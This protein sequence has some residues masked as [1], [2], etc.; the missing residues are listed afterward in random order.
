MP[1]SLD[2]ISP[3]TPMG[4]NLIADG[5]TFRVWAPNAQCRARPRRFQRPGEGRRQPAHART[6]TATGAASSRGR[7]TGTA[8]CSTSIGKGSEGPKRDPY[9][10]ELQTPFPS[11]C[12]IRKTDF[13]WHETGFVTPR[14]HN[15]V[16]YQ[17]HVGTFFTPNL[18]GKGGTF[19]D[20]ARKIPHLPSSA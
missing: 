7:R 17:L 16:I 2:H 1:A 9:A 6:P 5:A 4:A 18:P 15:F 10:R 12:I 3:D 19:L 8:T 20:V 14:F 13:P 11:D